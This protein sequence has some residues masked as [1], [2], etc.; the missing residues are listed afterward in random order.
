MRLG[1]RLH[2]IREFVNHVYYFKGLLC[3]YLHGTS[4]LKTDLDEV[5]EPEPD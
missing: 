2:R 4:T 3:C 1:L 5:P